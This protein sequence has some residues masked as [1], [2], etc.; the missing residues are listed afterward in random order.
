M[1]T[2]VHLRIP[3]EEAGE[4]DD[5]E[6]DVQMIVPA[7]EDTAEDETGTGHLKAGWCPGRVQGKMGPSHSLKWFHTTF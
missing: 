4:A 1:H 7:Q 2:C 6:D 5:D 3:Q